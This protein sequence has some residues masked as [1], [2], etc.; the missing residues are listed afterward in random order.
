MQPDSGHFRGGT[1]VT[2]TIAPDPLRSLAPEHRATAALCRF[3]GRLSGSVTL[4]SL[5]QGGSAANQTSIVCATPAQRDV[6]TVDVQV[7]F[8]G[9]EFSSNKFFF[10]YLDL[11]VHEFHKEQVGV[12]QQAP[13]LY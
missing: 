9:Q 1:L 6:G 13:T 7:S 2:V 4:G 10:T 12:F 8:N 3:G 5:A 11:S